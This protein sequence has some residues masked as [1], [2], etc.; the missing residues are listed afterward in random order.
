MAADTLFSRLRRSV[1]LL[2]REVVKFGAVGGIAFVVD[3][4]VFN[5][6]LHSAVGE[7]LGLDHKPLTAKTVSVL[8]ATVVAWVGNRYWTFRHRRR[9]SV[10]REFVLFGVMNA[11]GLAISLACLGFSR[12]ILD[13]DSPLADNISGNV[14]GLGLGTLFR[15]WA[16]RTFVFTHDHEPVNGEPT[17]PG[18]P[19]A[20]AEDLAEHAE[21][22]DHPH[23][24][25]TAAH[26]PGLDLSRR[27][28][29]S[30]S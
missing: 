2:Y 22:H 5:L 23:R 15:F 21:H 25:E 1:D 12:Y 16:Y 30:R 19:E 28:S 20:I 18:T 26:R 7:Q 9:A 29:P 8:V 17:P 4:G 11:A 24:P 10:R 13:L 14:I 6:L 3:T 27:E